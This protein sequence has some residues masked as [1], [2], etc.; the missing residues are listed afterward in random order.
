[1]KKEDIL[2][3]YFNFKCLDSD[4]IRHLKFDPTLDSL[5]DF[6]KL[7]FYPLFNLLSND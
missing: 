6:F 1:M 4:C 2:Y 7:Y 3:D 5:S